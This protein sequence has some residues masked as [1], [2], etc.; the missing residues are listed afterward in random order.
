MS[1][2]RLAYDGCAQVMC[3]DAQT[4]KF[5][6]DTVNFTVEGADTALPT[7]IAPTP[8]SRDSARETMQITQV[9]M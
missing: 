1:S 3:A 6:S 8:Q 4:A 5:P 7:E 2:F 9:V